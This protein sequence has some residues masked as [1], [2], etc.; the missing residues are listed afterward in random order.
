MSIAIHASGLNR[1]RPSVALLVVA[2]HGA[3]VVGLMFM[4]L[5]QRSDAQASPP[6]QIIEPTDDKPV[7][8][9]EP[10]GTGAVALT[11]VP[12]VPIPEPIVPIDDSQSTPPL[13]GEVVTDDPNPPAGREV[14]DPV[15]LSRTPLQFSALRSTDDYYPPR[16]IALGEVGVAQVNVC[17]DSQGRLTET[18]T[19]VRSAGHAR[20]DR[21]AVLWASEALRYTPATEAGS[22]VTACKGF[23]VNFSLK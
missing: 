3:L 4:Q 15:V 7:D 12:T 20:L 2:A 8:I 19:I 1:R 11:R 5:V 10:R 14:T 18:P 17:I 6:I 22:A 21:A 16:S 9:D 13:T 23:L